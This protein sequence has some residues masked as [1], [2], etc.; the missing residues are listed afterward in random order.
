[1]LKTTHKHIRSTAEKLGL[2]AEHIAQLLEI[3]A[4][5]EFEILLTSGKKFPAYRMQHSSARG[6]Y[7]GGIRFHPHVDKDEVRALATLMSFKTAVVNLPLGG[8][9]GGVVVDPKLLSESELEELA[10]KYVQH[11]EPFIGPHKDIPAPDVNT[12]PKIIDWMVDE[13]AR[14]TGDDTNAAFT[15]KSVGRGG[16]LG[17]DAATGRGGVIVLRTLLQRAHLQDKKLRIAVQGY[18]NVGAF[19]AEVVEQEQKNWHLVAATDSS[20]GIYDA[21]GLSAQK[22]SEWKNDRNSLI[23]YKSGKKISNE[24]II[25]LDVDV[26]VLAALGGVVHQENSSEIKAAFILELA[27]GPVDTSAEELLHKNGVNVVP[28]ILANAGGV[29]VSYLEW[30]QN[31]EKKQWALEKVNE[32]LEDYLVSATDTIALRAEQDA[33]DLKSAAFA[34][35]IERLVKAKGL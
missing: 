29:I 35:A 13:Y 31:L 8:G 6:P 1:M 23:S 26:L 12:N 10:R 16:S 33:A 25:A 27:N 5:H 9:K 34:V 28:D 7:K 3:E 21:N 17:R 2:S 20:G 22:L 24:D 15:G 11:L 18:G 30:L 19:F 4:E 32:M 14:L